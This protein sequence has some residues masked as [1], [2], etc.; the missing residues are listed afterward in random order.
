[1]KDFVQAADGSMW[2]NPGVAFASKSVE[3][4][5]NRE[6]PKYSWRNCVKYLQSNL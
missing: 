2:E 5:Q 3:R 1:M 4:F 6:Q